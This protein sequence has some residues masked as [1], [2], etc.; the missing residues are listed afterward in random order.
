MENQTNKRLNIWNNK[1]LDKYPYH[2]VGIEV[3]TQ[4]QER[5]KILKADGRGS[6]STG[7]VWTLPHLWWWYL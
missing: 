3:V 7:H 1:N 6:D 4:P 2:R 5:R